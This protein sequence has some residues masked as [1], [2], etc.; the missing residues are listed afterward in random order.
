MEILA[1]IYVQILDLINQH[2]KALALLGGAYLVSMLI[3]FNLSFFQIKYYTMNESTTSIINVL[4]NQVKKPAQSSRLY[5][6]TGLNY[7]LEELSEE[8]QRFF[9]G[10]FPYFSDSHKNLI[11]SAYNANDLF[12]DDSNL[13]M[14]IIAQD[15]GG[16]AYKTYLNRMN[17]E[18][19]ERALINYFGE[20]FLVTEDNLRQL[21]NIALFYK[22]RLP[23][24]KF[25][26]SIYELLQFSK[27][28]VNNSAIQI[29]HVINKDKVAET[30]FFEL[31]TKSVTM[32]DLASWIN[33]IN[34]VGILSTQEYAQFT[35]SY[36]TLVQLQ[37]QNLQYDRQLVDLYNL[38]DSVDIQTNE[39]LQYIEALSY[40]IEY[41]E[42][43]LEEKSESLANLSNYRT[44]ELYVVDSYGG[45]NYEAYIPEKSF[46]FGSYKPSN[47]QVQLSLTKSQP[48][49]PGVYTFTLRYLGQ[50]VNGLASYQEVS[51]AD[52][53]EI[54]TLQA[55]IKTLEEDISYLTS[56]QKSTMTE[57]NTVRKVNNYSENIDAIEEIEKQQ[58]ENNNKIAAH[59]NSIQLLFGIGE[60]SL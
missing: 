38:K 3:G 18:Q 2:K 12:F 14:G 17:L 44:L 19:Y 16:E 32:A 37:E 24:D 53:K 28:D 56:Q 9:N 21:Y 49:S 47:E 42:Y 27:G 35:N 6:K 20:L 7:I 10:Y 39:Q 1:K 25:Q 40:D 43:L 26:I 22:E 34:Q 30:L 4:S 46:F 57:I 11:V 5:F 55:E 8:T 29:L 51:D 15:G 58:A 13:I 54:S 41:K 50:S 59:K 48:R 23:L 45:G 33:I 31:K 36:N 60:V 52:W